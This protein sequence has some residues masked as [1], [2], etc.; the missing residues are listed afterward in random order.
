MYIEPTFNQ[1]LGDFF[2]TTV[3][4]TVKT[5]IYI[6][7]SALIGYYVSV[8]KDDPNIFGPATIFIN[9]GLV[10]LKNALDPKTPNI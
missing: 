5:G 9:M 1:K 4:K 6:A 2:N 10:A 7:L 8:M 3:G